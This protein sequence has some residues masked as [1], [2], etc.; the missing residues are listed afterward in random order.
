MAF[1]YF[2]A[3]VFSISAWKCSACTDKTECCYFPCERL[4][5][6]N[7]AQIGQVGNCGG[8]CTDGIV[9]DLNGVKHWELYLW[10]TGYYSMHSFHSY[11]SGPMEIE[12]NDQ[13][14]FN[15]CYN[16]CFAADSPSSAP[17]FSAEPTPAVIPCLQNCDVTGETTCQTNDISR[18]LFAGQSNM[19]GHSRDAKET[20]FTEIISILNKDKSKK[21]KKRKM[22]VALN[23]ATDA[24]EYS[25]ANEARLMWSL[26]KY[27][28]KKKINKDHKNVVCSWTDPRYMK[29]LDCE[30]PVSPTACGDDFGPELMFAHQF[31]KLDTPLKG[32]PVGIIKVASG[33][34]QIHADW[35][36]NSG[37]Y[38]RHM[39]NAIL[40]ANGSIEA[41]VWFQGEN[42]SFDDWNR[43]NYY[44]HL[45]EFIGDIRD[46]IYRSSAKFES[47][48]EV[49]VVIVELGM[50]RYGGK[51]TVI[52]AQREFVKNTANTA[53][54]NTGSHDKESKRLS[55]FYH[56]DAAAILIIGSRISKAVKD[57]LNKGGNANLLG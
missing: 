46:E 56:F 45:T 36:K 53:L 15:R 14:M 51:Q 9:P 25:S 28:K 29:T 41:F 5:L 33:G 10:K 27:L 12:G 6:D 48:V 22:K 44:T 4:R 23:E 8:D 11:D 42:D 54:V 16:Q 37:K 57:L 34:T 17:T 30:R 7:D 13:N 31:P 32:K 21:Y 43:D 19:E 40:A 3:F 20:L 49:P 47:A 24:Q 35:M 2:V 50:W 38:W 18:F 1:C 26:R 55:A 52:K 39:K